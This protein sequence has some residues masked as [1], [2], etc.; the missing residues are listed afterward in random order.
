[1][2]QKE[3][4]EIL[5][6]VNID[7][8]IDGEKIIITDKNAYIDLSGLISIPS[9]VVFNNIGSVYLSSLSSLPSGITFKNQGDVNLYN[10]TSLPSDT[11]FNNQGYIS[12]SWLTTLPS[13][14]VFNNKDGV[15]LDRL[16]WM[17][18]G[19][20]FNNQGFVGFYSLTTL[21]SG[22]V[23][24]NKDGVYLPFLTSMPDDIKV[25]DN[26][27]MKINNTKQAKGYTIYDC[28]YLGNNNHCFV[29]EKDGFTA[30]GETVK[31]AIE[32]V[33]F[34][35]VRRKL[36]NESIYL[37]TIVDVNHYR[38]ITGACELGISNWLK[39]NKLKKKKYKVSEILPILEKTHA[40]GVERFKELI[41]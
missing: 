35:I 17:S 5:K 29:A 24:N 16:I 26:Y 40:Y 39:E 38:M 28:N 15:Y 6:S 9:G 41:K 21:P 18:D 10:L 34:K 31:K 37:D 33:E 7:Y 1:M 12:L 14:I 4:I 25:F 2:K 11:I 36:Q 30:H 3:F 22:T 23:F 27:G 20:I 32:D 19:I 8:L 13:G